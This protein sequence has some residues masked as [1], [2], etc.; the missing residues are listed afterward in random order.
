MFKTTVKMTLRSH[1]DR[2]SHEN[3]QGSQQ[4]GLI[5]I[6]DLFILNLAFKCDFDRF[7]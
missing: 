3:K 1:N 2:G 5:K 6:P 4:F 7:A